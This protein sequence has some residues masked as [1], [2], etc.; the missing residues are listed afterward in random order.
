MQQHYQDDIHLEDLAEYC[1]LSRSYMA[2]FFKTHLGVTLG[3]YLRNIRAQRARDSLIE[4]K[5]SF[6]SIALEHGFSGLGSMNRAL[7]DSFGQNARQ[8]RNN[9]NS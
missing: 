4:T 9:T 7:E 3:E 5:E 6:T 1:H 2:R 8:I